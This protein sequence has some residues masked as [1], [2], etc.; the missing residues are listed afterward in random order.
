MRSL[1]RNGIY[2]LAAAILITTTGC[3]A[4]VASRTSNQGGGNILT[5][6]AKLGSDSIG[7]LNPDEWQILTDNA[8]TIAQQY[9]ANLGGI[10]SIPSL[11]D[12]EAAAV[13]TLLDENGVNT[14]ND[15]QLLADDIAAGN[16]TVPPE[17]ANFAA[18]L[19]GQ[20][21]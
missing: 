6:G 16:V 21:T 4:L 15:L 7:T 14:F 2:V 19:I 20:A 5:V 3:P 10:G 18:Q 8:A 1:R 11:T 9:G 12:A 17:L 13:V